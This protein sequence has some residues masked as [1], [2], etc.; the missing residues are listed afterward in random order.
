MLNIHDYI[1]EG[2]KRT[3]SLSGKINQDYILLS[4][5]DPTAFQVQT[6]GGQMSPYDEKQHLR[7]KRLLVLS[8]GMSTWHIKFHLCR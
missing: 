8:E 4:T 6:S 2:F 3:R 5:C 7:E 1:R